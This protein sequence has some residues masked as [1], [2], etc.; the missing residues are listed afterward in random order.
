MN[1]FFNEFRKFALRGNA[2]E[3]AVGVV[4]GA[5]F[6]GIITSLVNNI[7]TP[8]LG[9]LVG[10]VD[11][12]SFE[13]PLKGDAVLQY[14]LFIQSV[15]SFLVTAVALF[16]IVKGLNTITRRNKKEDTAKSNKEL[17]VLEEIRDLLKKK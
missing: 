5:A 8:P 17:L 12:S 13:I 3:L 14:G 2:I 7:I 15:I 1:E 4:V 6:N 11:F 16:L 10:N 9:L